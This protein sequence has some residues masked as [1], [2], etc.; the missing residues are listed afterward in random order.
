MDTKTDKVT[1]YT[2]PKTGY[3]AAILM[4]VL[5]ASGLSLGLSTLPIICSAILIILALWMFAHPKSYISVDKKNAVISS[6]VFG[7]KTWE[8]PVSSITK[9]ST[10]G[11][12]VG[13]IKIMNISYRQPS[14]KERTVR[15]GSKQTF[16]KDAFEEV[17]KELSVLN[18]SVQIPS[19]LKK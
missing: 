9:I 4:V 11:S 8:F 15:A 13:T 3:A 14:G 1:A 5:A 12:F 17:L 10:V 6:S 18:P 19:D 7:F 16:E 2:K